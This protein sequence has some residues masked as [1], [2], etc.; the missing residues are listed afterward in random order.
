V[1]HNKQ[2]TL[3]LGYSLI[4]KQVVRMRGRGLDGEEGI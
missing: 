1:G 4:P 2:R 3:F